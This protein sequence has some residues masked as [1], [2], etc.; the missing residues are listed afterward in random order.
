MLL[1]IPLYPS[2]LPQELSGKF[3]LEG[4]HCLHLKD[5]KLDLGVPNG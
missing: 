2:I 3:A 4:L 5:D 1:L